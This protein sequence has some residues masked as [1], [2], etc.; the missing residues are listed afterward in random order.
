MP[1]PCRLLS[2]QF[3]PF[4]ELPQHSAPILHPGTRHV[5]SPLSLPNRKT[6]LNKILLL[7]YFSSQG[8]SFLNF[9]PFLVLVPKPWPSSFKRGKAL[10]W[11]C[12]FGEQIGQRIAIST[13]NSLPRVS[14]TSDV[15]CCSTLNVSVLYGDFRTPP[16]CYYFGL[17]LTDSQWLPPLS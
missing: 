6:F 5:T 12:G 1:S 17:G 2:L 11:Y 16:G 10:L 4:S 15:L 9:C 3:P 14:N 13:P 8:N 7:V